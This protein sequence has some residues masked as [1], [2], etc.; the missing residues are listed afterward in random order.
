MV[1]VLSNSIASPIVH[2]SGNSMIDTIVCL[3]D[4]N[5]P[6]SWERRYD[7]KAGKVYYINHQTK[8]THWE[9]PPSATASPQHSPKPS[10]KQT[11]KVCT[12]PNPIQIQT[13]K[14]CIATNATQPKT[15]LTYDMCAQ[16]QTQLKTN[17]QGTHSPKHCPKQTYKY[18]QPQTQPQ[19]KL[20]SYAQPQTQPKINFQG[21]HS[22]NLLKTSLQGVP[23]PKLSP[24]NK[25]IR[26]AQPQT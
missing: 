15:K 24:Q 23:S 12:A 21:M 6:A 9:L 2:D 26:Y 8:S 11:Y 1:L 3:V 22:P 16:P 5:I 18:A 25:C 20:T 10:S 4:G 19:N 17:L 7:A 13:Y 14:A